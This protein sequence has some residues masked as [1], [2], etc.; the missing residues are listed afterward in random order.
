[1]RVVDDEPNVRDTIVRMLRSEGY[2]VRTAATLTEGRAVLGDKSIAVD[3][4]LA[5]VMLGAERGTDLIADCRRDRPDA[6]VVIMSGYAADLGASQTL[7]K[8]GA[9]FLAKPFA[10]DALLDAVRHSVAA[11]GDRARREPQRDLL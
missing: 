6:R 8:S 1:V 2:E 3:L 10:R 9:A 5:D 4:L 7:A 11:T